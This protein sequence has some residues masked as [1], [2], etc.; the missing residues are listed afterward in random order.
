MKIAIANDLLIATE[1]L[2]RLLIEDGR[3]QV[4]WVARDGEQAVALCREQRPDLILMDLIMPLLD[5]IEATRQIM[6]HSPCAVLIVTATPE[7]STG[8][9][10][11]AMGAGALDVTATPALGG[12]DDGGDLLRKIAT[13]ERLVGTDQRLQRL[14]SMPVARARP[15]LLRSAGARR[16]VAIGAS[17]GGPA[18]LAK[19]L[20][21]WP[22]AADTAV[23]L[24]QHIDRRFVEG[25]ARWLAE[26]VQWPVRL[27]EAGTC[28]QPGCIHIA[29]ADDHLVLT[30]EGAFAYQAEPLDYPYRPSVDVFFHSLARHWRQPAIGVLLTGMGEDGAS[31]LLALRRAGHPT[32]AQDQASCAVYGMPRAAA[33]LEAAEWVLTPN[34]INAKLKLWASGIAGRGPPLAN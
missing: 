31:G 7:D 3:H 30:A 25:F 15:S 10:F 21:D 24:V 2:R 20:G 5:G 34:E 19:V 1:A 13:L 29:R 11:R 28:P 6:Q 16:L 17:T 9:V 23:V 4:L 8:A 27:V 14:P 12:G 22:V 33:R 18:A 26:Q 32:A